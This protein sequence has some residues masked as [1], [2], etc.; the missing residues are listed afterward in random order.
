[1]NG[2]GIMDISQKA[3]YIATS[4]KYRLMMM[5]DQT[6]DLVD[7]ITLLNEETEVELVRNMAVERATNMGNRSEMNSQS[8]RNDGKYT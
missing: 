8:Q 3:L 6:D 5:Q 7:A 2:G 1:M 4:L